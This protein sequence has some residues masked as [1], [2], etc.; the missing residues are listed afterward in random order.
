MLRRT[1]RLLLLSALVISTLLAEPALAHRSFFNATFE[2]GTGDLAD[3]SLS[4]Q[5]GFSKD[6]PF[7]LYGEMTHQAFYM[8][9]DD[10]GYRA[11][12]EAGYESTHLGLSLRGGYFSGPFESL[13]YKQFGGT[14]FYRFVPWNFMTMSEK[15]YLNHD[16]RKSLNDHQT[17][18]INESLPKAPLLALSLD[19]YSISSSLSQLASINPTRT[20][21]WLYA[22]L[23]PFWTF[24]P[25]VAFYTY[26][27]LPSADLAGQ[28]SYGSRAL[29]LIK[30][31]PNG[32]YSGIYGCPDNT[33]QLYS[34][35]K[36]FPMI[37]IDAAITRASL[38]M[39]SYVAYSAWLGFDRF[40]N[41]DKS[42][43]ISPSYEQV[44]LEGQ[45]LSFFSVSLRYGAGT[46]YIPPN[47]R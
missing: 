5:Y 9:P 24:I 42:W 38:D 12:G 34:E 37:T 11:L 21:L 29:R 33:F 14:F 27:T 26:N 8:V 10:V 13:T 45:L 16:E 18:G 6:S 40:L 30:L 25:S 1:L 39:P 36:L 44:F 2:S 31:G 43:A 32:Q 22:T 41:A 19:Q 35:V 23:E 28:T 47:Q 17:R 15:L 7:Y 20:M 4:G 46:H 3:E